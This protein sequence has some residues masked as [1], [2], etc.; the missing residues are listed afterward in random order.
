METILVAMRLRRVVQTTGRATMLAP[1]DAMTCSG[2][3]A[4]GTLL[5]WAQNRPRRAA[6]DACV[7]PMACLQRFPGFRG[8]WSAEILWFASTVPSGERTRRC[9]RWLSLASLAVRGTS[10]RRYH[11]EQQRRL[12]RHI[13]P[14]P[15]QGPSSGL[16]HRPRLTPT[17]GRRPS[18]RN[19]GTSWLRFGNMGGLLFSLAQREIPRFAPKSKWGFA[20]WC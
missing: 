7:V 9:N 1:T 3:A 19:V 2:A 20:Q 6:P 10:V 14:K 12:E 15:C 4:C 16:W 13:L 5:A 8:S 11:A 18:S 17:T